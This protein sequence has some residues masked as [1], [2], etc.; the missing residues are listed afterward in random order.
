MGSVSCSINRWEVRGSVGPQW[1]YKGHILVN[2]ELNG[3]WWAFSYLWQDGGI[4]GDLFTLK[5]KMI[6]FCEKTQSHHEIAI[7]G[8]G[9]LGLDPLPHYLVYTTLNRITITLVQVP[10]NS[11]RGADVTQEDWRQS[12]HAQ[13]RSVLKYWASTLLKTSQYRQY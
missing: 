9:F 12:S 7:L 4:V 2:K 10:A 3:E 5:I 13:T 8:L 11:V 1:H 6:F